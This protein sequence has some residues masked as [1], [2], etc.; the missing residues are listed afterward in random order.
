MIAENGYS[1][2]KINNV[3]YRHLKLAL[4]GLLSNSCTSLHLFLREPPLIKK[5]ALLMNRS[6]SLKRASSNGTGII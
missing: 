6:T 5:C 1:L 4:R 2:I 3:A